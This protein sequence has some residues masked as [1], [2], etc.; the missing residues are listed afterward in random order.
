MARDVEKERATRVLKSVKKTR[1]TKKVRRQQKQ[2]VD[3]KKGYKAR[4]HARDKGR[5]NR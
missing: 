5:D 3:K 2:P 4:K 1:E